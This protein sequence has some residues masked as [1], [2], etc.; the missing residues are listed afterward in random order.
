M[1]PDRALG[2][3]A[4]ALLALVGC[5]ETSTSIGPR[6]ASTVDL[7]AADDVRDVATVDAPIVDAPIVDAPIVDAPPLCSPNPPGTYD[8]GTEGI[9]ISICNIAHGSGAP[10]RV[11]VQIESA[12]GVP[13]TWA[14]ITQSERCPCPPA[15]RRP[16]DDAGADGGVARFPCGPASTCAVGREFCRTPTGPGICPSPDAGFCPPG[17]PGCAALPD[18]SCAPIPAACVATPTCACVLQETC[19]SPAAGACSTGPTGGQT[20]GCLGV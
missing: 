6:D 2:V 16:S 5:S 10:C 12:D 8:C 9:A 19:G 3:H 11:C 13:V 17:C 14:A 7:G 1:I 15:Y 18:P 4:L 20:A